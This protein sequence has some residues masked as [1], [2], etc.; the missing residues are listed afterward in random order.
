MRKDT[1]DYETSEKIAIKSGKEALS[2]APWLFDRSKEKRG[3]FFELKR[4]DAVHPDYYAI[5]CVDGVGTKLFL[6]PWSS[7]Y[8]LQPIDGIGMNA[9]DM[10][11]A[12][13]AYPDAINLYF[14]VQTGIEEEHMG[15]IMEGF[16]DAIA[17]IS[18]PWAP[19]NV[20]IGKLETASLD[21]M[22]SLG[23][24]NKGFDIG[25]VMTG[26]IK[27]DKVPNLT[28]QPGHI[29]VGIS[30]TGLH[31]NGYTSA[32][33]ILFTSDVEYRKEWKS[34]YRG[35]YHFNDKPSILEG[36]TVLEAL[37]VPTAAYLTEASKIGKEL[38]NRDIY[39]VNITG[40]GLHNFNRA[41]QEVSLEIT[42]PLPILPVHKFLIQE[43]GWTPE[44]AYKKQN[45]GM[46]FAYVC[47]SLDIAEKII[48]SI[49]L[50]GKNKAKI[51]GEVRKSEEKELKTTIHKPYEGKPIDFIGYSN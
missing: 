6:A 31:S 44:I 3:F 45:M 8:R 47:P 11:T 4:N 36:K 15:E 24:A 28:P 33:H 29:I 30:S 12:I 5:H 42:D 13:H 35:K 50:R 46:G 21:E 9:N 19:F 10:A 16:V 20:N 22:I 43:S 27:K 37:Q 51:V 34:Q 25:I 17:E 7:N 1:A 38:D 41:G 40:N 48:K 23:I 2:K 32:R 14:A 18:I 49:N 39:G 26:Y